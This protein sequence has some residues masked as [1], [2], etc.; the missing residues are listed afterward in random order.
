MMVTKPILSL[1]AFEAGTMCVLCALVDVTEKVR[2]EW[3][4][5]R[6]V[7]V[8]HDR[9]SGIGKPLQADSMAE[10]KKRSLGSKQDSGSG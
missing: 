2:E 10:M 5:E 7:R 4:H 1:N 9:E 3:G 8:H 6:E